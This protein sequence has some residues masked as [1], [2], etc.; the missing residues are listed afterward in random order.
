MFYSQPVSDWPSP[1]KPQLT[2]TRLMEVPVSYIPME[3]SQKRILSPET[4]D[5]A[6]DKRIRH[7]SLEVGSFQPQVLATGPEVFTLADLMAVIRYVRVNAATKKD[8]QIFATKND[9]EDLEHRVSAQAEEISELR[10]TTVTQ[11]ARLQQVEESLSKQK[12]NSHLVPVYRKC[13]V[14]M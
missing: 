3:Q 12:S 1:A 2:E 5:I 11:E 7:Q 9:V 13:S 14:E 10:S 6:Q 4:V 8:L